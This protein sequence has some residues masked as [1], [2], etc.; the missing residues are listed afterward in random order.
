MTRRILLVHGLSSSAESW[1]RV[2]PY[3][4][5]RGWDVTTIDLRGHGTAPR[6]AG[7]ELDG[8][9]AD[10]PGQ[11]WD[12]VLGHSL[13]GATVVLAAG[14]PGFARSLVLLDP[15]LEIPADDFEAILAEQLAELGLTEH[16]IA[17]LKP[18][19][20]ER[21]R[22]AKL[23]GIRATDATVVGRSLTDNPHWNV[24]A[25]ARALTMP[26]LILGG[27]HAVYSMLA[28]S[29]AEALTAANPLI[30]YRVIEGAGHSPHRDKP[31]ETLAAIANWL[32]D[33]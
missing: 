16:S 30:E 33:H 27:D 6:T 12:A 3:L 20:H 26:T 21:D 29:T 23:A 28:T 8:Y 18:H 2:A 11:D 7:Y 25:E 13:G 1:W 14:R 19:W 22:A 17:E 31:D 4:E 10:L 24:V 32:L 5:D 9:A 15:L